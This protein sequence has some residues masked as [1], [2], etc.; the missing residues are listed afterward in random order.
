MKNHLVKKSEELLAGH[1]NMNRKDRRIAKKLGTDIPEL[2]EARMWVFFPV[3]FDLNKK[4]AYVPSD[5]WRI[6]YGKW[7]LVIISWFTKMEWY[8]SYSVRLPKMPIEKQ[9]E[10]VEVMELMAKENQ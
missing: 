9:K 4:R 8:Q 1:R 2:I 7:V 3:I 5:D 10:C 6:K